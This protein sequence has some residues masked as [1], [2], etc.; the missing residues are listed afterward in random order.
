MSIFCVEYGCRRS[1]LGEYT[2]RWRGAGR[3]YSAWAMAS[4][5]SARCIADMYPYGLS[6]C[7]SAA[8]MEVD[9]VFAD[10]RNTNSC[11]ALRCNGVAATSTALRWDVARAKVVWRVHWA[12]CC[13]TYVACA[14]RMV[15]MMAAVGSDTSKHRALD[16][17]RELHGRRWPS[18]LVM[19][20]GCEAGSREGG[21]EKK[22]LSHIYMGALV[23]AQKRG[24]AAT[25][26]GLT[27]LKVL[28]V[29]CN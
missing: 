5:Y 28:P 8:A 24:Q 16:M 15:I 10:W 17:G 26:L 29:K 2:K 20:L 9:A 7:M 21:L 19:A 4:R 13:V 3:I 27:T 25:A 6:E 18:S 14:N 1:W 22:P 12:R 11:G 23:D